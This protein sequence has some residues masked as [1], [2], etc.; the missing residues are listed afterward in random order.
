[1]P[2]RQAQAG[3]HEI[4]APTIPVSKDVT[5]AQACALIYTEATAALPHAAYPALRDRVQRI[6]DLAAHA[7]A[8][9]AHDA[10]RTVAHEVERRD[11]AARQ[12]DHLLHAAAAYRLV[13]SALGPRVE[14][15][16]LEQALAELRGIL[17]RRAVEKLDLEV[18]R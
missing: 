14:R 7:S 2:H 18:G 11:M 10:A 5:P 15:R 4:S 12:A 8:K 13:A 3:G 16:K 6:Q 17:G 9:V 1:M